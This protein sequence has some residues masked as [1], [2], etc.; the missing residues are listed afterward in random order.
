MVR[1]LSAG[2]GVGLAMA[3][4]WLGADLSGDD[5]AGRPVAAAGQDTDTSGDVE[6]PGDRGRE[7]GLSHGPPPWVKA[8][9]GGHASDGRVWRSAWGAMSPRERERIMSRFAEAHAAGMRS[10]ARCVSDGSDDC[11]KPLPPG[12]AKKQLRP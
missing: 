10:W 1:W 12:L 9:G 11:E 3:L 7:W 6:D 2:V 5:Q 4:M 8:P